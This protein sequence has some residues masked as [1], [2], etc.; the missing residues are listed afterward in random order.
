MFLG[1]ICPI[2]F[3]LLAEQ[4]KLLFLD[5]QCLRN[6]EQIKSPN[7]L[8][9]TWFVCDRCWIQS[10]GS[11]SFQ[12]THKELWNY[13]DV[14]HFWYS[15]PAIVRFFERILNTERWIGH[16][17]NDCTFPKPFLCR[18]NSSLVLSNVSRDVESSMQCSLWI[19][20]TRMKTTHNTLLLKK[21]DVLVEEMW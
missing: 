14:S 10:I 16:L 20:K 19:E 5:Y 12:A 13:V 4:T 8:S 11:L 7:D 6:I 2:M 1:S 15:L 9:L 21:L 3:W 17:A 18:P